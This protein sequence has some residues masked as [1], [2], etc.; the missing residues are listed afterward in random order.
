MWNGQ[1]KVWSHYRKDIIAADAHAAA[2]L[3]AYLRNMA[4]HKTHVP[5]LEVADLQKYK[6][7]KHPGKVKAALRDRTSIPFVFVIGKN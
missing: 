3:S 6:V 1:D 7:I 4:I 5:L 2:F